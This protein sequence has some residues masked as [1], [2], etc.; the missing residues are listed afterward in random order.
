MS[1]TK[2]FALSSL[3]PEEWSKRDW[4]LLLLYV[5]IFIVFAPI[6]KTAAISI[7]ETISLSIEKYRIRRS[8][9]NKTSLDQQEER[10]FETEREALR[11]MQ[12]KRQQAAVSDKKTGK[13]DLPMPNFELRVPA[14]RQLSTETKDKTK[15]PKDIGPT[16]A[17][18]S[19]LRKRTGGSS[20]SNRSI[21]APPPVIP[22]PLVNVETRGV[23]GRLEEERLLKAQQD[24]EYQQSILKELEIQKVSKVLSFLSYLTAIL[25]T[26]AQS[27]EKLEEKKKAIFEKVP[28]EPEVCNIRCWSIIALMYIDS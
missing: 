19:T 11:A 21:Y 6:V 26:V 9:S 20:S 22:Q 4:Q 8:L 18:S 14:P 3:H 23:N 17:P 2:T 5:C 1:L 7:I 10:N 16:A 28:L 12:Q 24:F 15:D 25:N 27:T 13:A